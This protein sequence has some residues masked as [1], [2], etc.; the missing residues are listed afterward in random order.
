MS[1]SR[2][3]GT[4]VVPTALPMATAR[5][6]PGVY[7]GHRPNGLLAYARQWNK[8]ECPWCISLYFGVSGRSRGYMGGGRFEQQV[9]LS[10]LLDYPAKVHDT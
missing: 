1:R 7:G 6:R 9:R 4:R 8:A 5:D 2:H 3:E 10:W